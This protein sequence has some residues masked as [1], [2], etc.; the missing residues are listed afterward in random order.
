MCMPYCRETQALPLPH[1]WAALSCYPCIQATTKGRGRCQCSDA[2]AQLPYVV[3]APVCS[4]DHQLCYRGNW[5]AAPAWQPNT[6]Y[7]PGG[8]HLR[9]H[10][11]RADTYG[12][13]SPAPS[14]QPASA[15][16]WGGQCIEGSGQWQQAAAGFGRG[17]TGVFTR[18]A[19]LQRLTAAVVFSTIAVHTQV[20]SAQYIQGSGL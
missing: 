7:E 19:T 12:R 1:P 4:Q 18:R 20:V 6:G 13:G 3:H 16:G 17:S 15:V 5:A 14:S 9:E 8:A 10:P 11:R 2:G